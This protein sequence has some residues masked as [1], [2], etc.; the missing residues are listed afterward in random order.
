MNVLV[1][2]SSPTQDAVANPGDV[3][4]AVT[5]DE[6]V[7]VVLCEVVAADGPVELGNFEN[8]E[9]RVERGTEEMELVLNSEKLLVVNAEVEN[10]A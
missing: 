2:F 8:L 9:C 5:R 4:V 1:L 7:A 10:D 6:A 3:D